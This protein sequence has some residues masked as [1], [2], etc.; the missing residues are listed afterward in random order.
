M[1]EAVVELAELA[2]AFLFSTTH[3]E[4]EGRWF[5]NSWPASL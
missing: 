2:T 5:V 4:E 3:C 1:Q